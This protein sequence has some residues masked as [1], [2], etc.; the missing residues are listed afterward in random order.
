MN[1]RFLTNVAVALVAGFVVVASQAFAIAVTGWVTFGVALGILALL[2]VSQL[3][4]RRGTIQRSLDAIAGVLGVW[5]VVASVVFSGSTLMWLSF[6]EALAFV[7]IA[8]AGL[9]AHE[10]STERVVH[11][12][13]VEHLNRES[14]KSYAPAA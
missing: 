2:G 12:L 4:Q 7:A 8:L 10:L 14:S 1:F 3:D 13:D 5:T 9:V 11:T 6:A